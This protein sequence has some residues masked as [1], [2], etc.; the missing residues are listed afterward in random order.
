MSS[1]AIIGASIGHASD[2][3]S[4]FQ[5]EFEN[6]HVFR[7]QPP[8]IDAVSLAADS[9]GHLSI[10]VPLETK[11]STSAARR[12][13]EL[14]FK[15]ARLDATDE[16]NAEFEALQKARRDHIPSRP[17]VFLDQWRQDKFRREILEVLTRN[18]EFI[19]PEDKAWLRASGQAKGA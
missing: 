11:W 1:A 6:A 8:R 19:R 12:F 15:R 5:P 7:M 3:L 17:E 14:S 13:A 4:A 2:K 16:E 18:V 9:P 10:N